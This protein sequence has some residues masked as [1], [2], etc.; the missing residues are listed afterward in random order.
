ML[1]HVYEGLNVKNVYEGLNVKNVY[2][3]LN[4]RSEVYL[5]KEYFCKMYLTCVSSKL[6]K[7]IFLWTAS[8][9]VSCNLH[10][11]HLLRT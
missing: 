9:T 1:E 8:L 5:S 6:S 11:L 10:D 7:F 2:E 3:G 4:A